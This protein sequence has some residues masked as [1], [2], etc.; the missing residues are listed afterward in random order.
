[1]DAFSLGLGL[2]AQGLRWRDVGRLSLIIS[3]F[4]LLLPL[5]GVWIGDVLYARF[6]DIVQKITAVVMMFLGSQMIVK[7]LQFEMGI[8]PPPFRAHFLQLVGFAFGVSIDA[9]S[10]GLTLGTLGMTPVV[11]AAMFALLSGALS[12]VGLYIGRQVNARLGRYG[13]LAGGAILAFLGLKFFW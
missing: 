5:L 10:V 1:M 7:S 2:G 11:P 8:Q 4:H 12:M 9:L 3:L 6:G 13:Q